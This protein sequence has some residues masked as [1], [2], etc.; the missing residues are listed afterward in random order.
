[1]QQSWWTDAVCN[2]KFWTET[3]RIDFDRMRVGGAA[4]TRRLA[5]CSVAHI[6]AR[7]AIDAGSYVVRNL[8]QD[9]RT[10]CDV[11]RLRWLAARQQSTCAACFC[12]RQDTAGQW[13]SISV[14]IRLFRPCLR[15]KDPLGFCCRYLVFVTVRK[16]IR[17]HA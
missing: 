13:A 10:Q 4:T 9:K 2:F 11:Q 6:T 3:C 14:P 16:G 17:I 15:S 8:R 1:M 12:S 7:R 5:D